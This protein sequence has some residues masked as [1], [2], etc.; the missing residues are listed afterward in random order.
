M[1]LRRLK[2]GEE[3]VEIWS[4]DGGIKGNGSPSALIKSVLPFFPRLHIAQ[5]SNEY[6]LPAY[7]IVCIELLAPDAAKNF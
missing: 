2:N 3:D 4:L 1:I 7:N 6:Y 5:H